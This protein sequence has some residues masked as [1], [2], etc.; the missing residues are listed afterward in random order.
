[1]ARD[2]KYFIDVLFRG[3]RA[4]RNIDKLRRNL[5][6][7]GRTA[8]GIGFGRRGLMGSI[9]PGGLL[10]GGL[11]GGLLG[12]VKA[13]A[14]GA[15]RI[16]GGAV[17]TGVGIIKGGVK[18][19]VGALG[20][21]RKAATVGAVGFI[22]L[23]SVAVASAAN[24]E[25]A[26]SKVQTI[27]NLGPVA[28][29]VRMELRDLAVETGRA[30]TEVFEGYYQ[31][32]SAGFTK[33]AEAMKFL[34]A[35]LR[36]SIAGWTEFPVVVQATS[37][38][39]RNFNIDASRT[40]EVMD[41]LLKT[42]DVGQIEL[43]QLAAVIGGV[44]NA[45]ASAGASLD[46]M[47][48]A[49]GIMAQTGPPEI[50]A[51]QLRGFLLRL[52]TTDP[53]ALQRSGGL[54]GYLKTLQG[55]SVPDLKRIFPDRRALLGVSSLI[56]LLPELEEAIGRVGSAGGKTEE[57]FGRRMDTLKAQAAR[58]WVALTDLAISYGAPIAETIKEHMKALPEGLVEWRAAAASA[59]AFI[60]GHL[61]TLLTKLEEIGAWFEGRT[62]S[63]ESLKAGAA[64]V[65][66]F[67]Q[68]Q[69]ANVFGYLD[70][71]VDLLKLAALDGVDA[72]AT[73]L[74]GRFT[75]VLTDITLAMR[76]LGKEMIAESEARARGMG[77]HLPPGAAAKHKLGVGLVKGSATVERVLAM[78]AMRAIDA[79]AAGQA[80]QADRDAVLAR[81]AGYAQAIADAAGGQLPGV[82]EAAFPKVDP[83]VR[84]Q[85]LADELWQ[86][87]E[88][89]R[90]AR[91]ILSR[92]EIAADL[93]KEPLVRNV[94]QAERLRGEAGQLRAVIAPL[95]WAIVEDGTVTADELAEL[96]REVRAIRRVVDR[97]RR[98]VRG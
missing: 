80:R 35:T 93:M 28:Q 70:A 21:V 19:A 13:A 96:T 68:S 14:G 58:T 42:V 92:E 22:A 18:L 29:E 6:S 61:D 95:L 55:M 62:V 60:A 56:R 20:A 45:A 11:F 37:R 32:I 36:G 79:P 53:G 44:A 90:L 30:V 26:W 39:M 77:R 71:R 78:A 48:A 15:L 64:G 38:T 47:L 94:A 89:Q 7:L 86:L 72:A 25:D 40:R 76:T 33:P 10:G 59:G 9:I 5:R 84:Q 63:W 34:D 50:V 3:N 82:A 17:R 23:T 74:S 97:G 12:G 31:V 69:A 87:P 67:I 88:M 24:V 2:L 66:A 85:N 43:P 65:G 91:M 81:A 98:P 8:K 1:M 4:G 83:A 57:N 49:L 16:V 46:E 75:G 73:L 51:T 54:V 27:I 52:A 41:K